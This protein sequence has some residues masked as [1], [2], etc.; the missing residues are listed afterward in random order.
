MKIF[1]R[2]RIFKKVRVDK[3]YLTEEQKF[4][5]EQCFIM[6]DQDRSGY[7][8]VIE[9]KDAMKALGVFLKKNEIRNYMTKI[10]KDGSG[11]IELDEFTSLMTEVLDKRDA[12][13][14]FKKVFRCYD[15]D[16]DGKI[17]ITNL[18]ECADILELE[19]QMNDLNLEKMIEIG[20]RKNNGYVD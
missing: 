9:L 11:T 2:K 13:T 12:S 3:K 7:L 20:D 6:F 17:N 16:D 18:K 8:D 19:N 15:N 4:E 14:E 5:I 1:K 10:D